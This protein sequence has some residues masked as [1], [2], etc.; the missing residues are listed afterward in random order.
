MKKIF[1][2]GFVFCLLF[3]TSLH[4]NLLSNLA[5]LD[6]CARVSFYCADVQAVENAT[7]QK[8][9]DGAILMC[10]A[11]VAKDV[12]KNVKNCFGY[13]I[14]FN[15]KAVLDQILSQIKVVKTEIQEALTSYYG[16]ATGA[17]FFDFLGGQKINVQVAVGAD[18][19]VVG[20]PIILGSY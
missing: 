10:D 18:Y 15:E 3:V 13:S 11:D 4:G 8:N 2:I 7:L 19:I 6:A 20:S 5:A 14:R 1:L 9:G 16:L 12:Y 17:I